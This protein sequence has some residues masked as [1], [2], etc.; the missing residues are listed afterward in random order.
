MGRV[1]FALAASH[2]IQE[3][4]QEA[5]TYIN[6]SVEMNSQF[7]ARIFQ[8]IVYNE[9]GDI[10]N[11]NKL[12]EGFRIDYPNVSVKKFNDNWLLRGIFRDR[13]NEGMIK[14]GLL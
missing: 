1:Y 9:M 3:N 10:N 8:I 7:P 2:F 4:N 14:V 13:F 5:L 12:L 6:R 11:S